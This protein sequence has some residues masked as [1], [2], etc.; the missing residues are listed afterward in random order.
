VNSHETGTINFHQEGDGRELNMVTGIREVV[1]F[2]SN[3][4]QQIVETTQW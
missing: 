4:K 1:G 3:K 2:D